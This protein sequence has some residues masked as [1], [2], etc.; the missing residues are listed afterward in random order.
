MLD[1][2]H[3]RSRRFLFGLK[4][5]FAIHATSI[6]FNKGLYGLGQVTPKPSF[7]IWVTQAHIRAG[8]RS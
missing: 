4:L 2:T 3:S 6:R 5:V 1:E 8:D 7:P